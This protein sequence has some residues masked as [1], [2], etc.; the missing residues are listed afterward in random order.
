VATARP[1]APP[2][3]DPIVKNLLLVVAVLFC[4]L[5]VPRI[6]RVL[7]RDRGDWPYRVKTPLSPAEQVAYHRLV[8]ALPE[9]VVLARVPLTSFLRVRKGQNWTEWYDRIDQKTVDFLVCERDFDVVMVIELDDPTRDRPGRA[10]DV[11]AKTRAL[12][13]AGITLIRW[14][15]DALPDVAMIRSIVADVRDRDFEG[16]DVVTV[17]RIEPRLHVSRVDASNDPSMYSDRTRS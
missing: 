7:A 1:S 4:A 6:V 3:A 16:R 11:A 14:R 9:L 12:T 13:A 8:D 2:V 5:V 15:A 17:E 10:R